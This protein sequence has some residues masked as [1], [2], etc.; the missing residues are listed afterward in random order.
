MKLNIFFNKEN[1][2]IVFLF[3]FS[4]FFN[5]HY[6]NRGIFPVDSFAHFDSGFRIL[7]GDHPFRDYWIVSGPFVDYLQATFFYLFGVN[8]QSYVLHAS[9]INAILTI[10]TFL[11]L[12]KFNLNNYY[13]F[14]YSLFFSI[15]AYPS[16]GTPFVDHHSAF[17]SLLGIYSLI[18]GIQSKKK[19]YW[20]LIPILF[21]FAFLS[22]Q[23][24]SIYVIISV[25]LILI[26]FLF[27]KKDNYW[28][29][30]LIFSSILFIFLLLVF[31]WTQ[32]ISLS[33][34]IEQ[35]ILYPQTIRNL[36]VQNFSFN[37]ISFLGHFKFIFLSIIPLFFINF[38]KL[39]LEKNYIKQNNFFYFLIL[40]SFTL[41]LIFHQILTKNQTFIFFLIPLLMAFSHISLNSYQ[42]KFKKI[43]SIILIS[44]VLLITFKYHLRFNENRKF[45]ELNQV[46]FKSSIK[47]SEID[48]KFNGLKWI[49]PAYKNNVQ[50]E[51][52]LIKKIKSFLIND[53]RSKMLISN[54]SFFSGLLNQNLHSPSRWYLSDGTDYPLR[55]NKYFNSYKNL[56]IKLI[57][58]NKIEVIYVVYPLDDRVIYDY[59]DKSCFREL[60]KLNK[61]KSYELENCEE[62]NG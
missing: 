43:V 37:L 14:I 24:P 19:I 62:I 57:K 55:N 31:G 44:L 47:G 28:I 16:S 13:S 20:I 7:L 18:M 30:Y 9:L 23:V 34:F 5:Q 42:F 35:Y 46:N 48:K 1:W 54:Y 12:K 61:L 2:F 3:L 22:K 53:S 17:F 4:L 50:E 39:I 41:S 29:K 25:I 49:T 52:I 27:L 40:L 38:K 56:V 59:L 51:L 60:K 21:G 26:F 36:R 15:L 10:T 45:H 8:W 33:S 58:N 32:G 6:G 11:I